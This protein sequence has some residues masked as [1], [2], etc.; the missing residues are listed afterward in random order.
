MKINISVDRIDIVDIPGVVDGVWGQTLGSV[1]PLDIL[2]RILSESGAC[3]SEKKS[4][5]SKNR[6]SAW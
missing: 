6:Q 1:G 4:Q 2:R 5:P 3:R